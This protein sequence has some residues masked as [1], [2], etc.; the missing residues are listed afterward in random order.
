MQIIAPI[1]DSLKDF[2]HRSL[3]FLDSELHHGCL[4]G[5]VFYWRLGDR[6]S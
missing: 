5:G 4:A 2:F 3:G 6:V 1:L